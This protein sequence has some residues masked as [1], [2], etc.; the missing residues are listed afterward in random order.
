MTFQEL[1]RTKRHNVALVI[2][3]GINRY[4]NASDTN[5]WNELLIGLAQKYSMAVAP[6]IPSGITLTEFYDLL[7]LKSGHATKTGSLQQDFCSPMQSWVPYKHHKRIVSWA[8]ENCSPILTT[9]FDDVLARSVGCR[10][11]PE[12]TSRFTDFYPWERYF[13]LDSIERP[14][15]N[16]GIWHINGMVRYKRSIRLGLTHYMGSVERARGWIHKSNERRLFAGK[17]VDSWPGVE[18]WLH[19][20]FNKPLLIFGL[21]LDE[22]EVFLRWLL[23]ERAR[24]FSK[25]P[26]RCKEAWYAYVGAESPGKLYFLEGIGVTPVQARN[27]DELYGASTWQLHP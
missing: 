25:F 10:L 2:G 17:N 14:D 27:F 3:N 24:Y 8:K 18:T 22:N 9:N 19:I 20:V 21:A 16:F 5:S 7:E 23:I 4:G 6:C 11:L 15:L 13:G 26:E 12:P 1:V